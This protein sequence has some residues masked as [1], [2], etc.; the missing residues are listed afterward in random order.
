V[1][2][3]TALFRRLHAECTG[4]PEYTGGKPARQI[5]LK[6]ATLIDPSGSEAVRP[7]LLNVSD[8]NLSAGSPLCLGANDNPWNFESMRCYT[9]HS[10]V[11]GGVDAG[12]CSITAA[13]G[14]II[15][16]IRAWRG[17]DT[18]CNDTYQSETIATG[19]NIRVVDATS[20]TATT[21]T[22]TQTIDVSGLY[23]TEQFILLG[24][25]LIIF[26]MAGWIGF[27]ISKTPAPE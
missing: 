18:S 7:V 25:A 14:T 24:I 10:T 15:S 22:E 11:G 3:K 8:I 27:Q 12:S 4:L 23:R 21:G 9:G 2:S 20:T 5:F 17:V 26:L 13:S 1:K 16:S 19:L 6:M